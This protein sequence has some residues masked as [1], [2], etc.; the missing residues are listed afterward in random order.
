MSR[1]G[2]FGQRSPY[3]KQRKK[4]MRKH[5]T[6]KE[7]RMLRALEAIRLLSFDTSE[8][9]S[10]KSTSPST[11]RT[12]STTLSDDATEES[13]DESRRSK[14][15]IVD[16]T[17]TLVHRPLPKIERSSIGGT[18][19]A[20]TGCSAFHRSVSNM[21]Y[22]SSDTSS[23]IGER[24]SVG[25]EN[26]YPSF[27]CF[28]AHS[29]GGYSDDIIQPTRSNTRRLSDTVLEEWNKRCDEEGSNDVLNL[30]LNQSMTL[31]YQQQHGADKSIGRRSS[32]T[33]SPIET[34]NYGSNFS[35]D[36][37]GNDDGISLTYSHDE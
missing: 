31:N 15:T 24:L 23:E 10:K 33:V 21:S 13:N 14:P 2:I 17:K 26:D 9:S 3:N 7:D 36:K 32:C 37:T 20:R 30:N 11:P 16:R 27:I 25:D 29:S 18:S 34:E 28:S 1:R 8:G 19:S 12:V 6:N 22:L 5:N 35:F 4:K